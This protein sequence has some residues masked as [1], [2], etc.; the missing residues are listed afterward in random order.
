MKRRA[1]V[2][3]LGTTAAASATVLGSGAF[4]SV[5]ADRSIT[6]EVADDDTALLVIDAEAEGVAGRSSLVNLG[7]GNKQAV[8]RIPGPEEDQIAGTDPEGIGKDSKY[9]FSNL[10][11]LR[12]QGTQPVTVYSEYDGTLEQISIFDSGDPDTL[13]TSQSNGVTLGTGQSFN[14][15]LYLESGDQGLGEY[16]ETLTVVAERVGGNLD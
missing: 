13:L 5:S 9:R 4:T 11:V 15:G 1:F 12:N 10:A 2:F 7:S 3:G 6:V 16:D 14:M 8:F